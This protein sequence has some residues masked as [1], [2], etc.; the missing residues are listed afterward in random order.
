LDDIWRDIDESLLRLERYS[1]GKVDIGI[2]RMA[3]EKALKKIE[4][5]NVPIGIVHDDFHYSNILVT[6][7][8]Q[9]CAIDNAGDYQACAY[10]DLATLITD[11][12]TRS[13]QILTGGAFISSTFIDACKKIILQAYFG[14]HAY[15]QKVIDFFCALAILNKWSEGLARFSVQRQRRMPAFF[16]KRIEGYFSKLLFEYL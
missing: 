14:Q 2:Y 12:Q 6:P 7:E 8:H 15:S 3:F 13:L 1:E 16:L 11:P 9:V 4:K 5:Q 10:V